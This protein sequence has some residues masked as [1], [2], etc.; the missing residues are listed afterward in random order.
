[1]PRLAKFGKLLGPRGLM[2][3]PKS[4]TISQNPEKKAKELEEGKI[5]FKTEREAPILHLVFGKMDFSDA[6]LIENFQALIQAIGPKN[7]KKAVIKST[8]S[9]GLKV[10]VK[11]YRSQ[12]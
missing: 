7:I 4:G 6:Q 11:G 12:P 1:M 9:P 3:N 8:I 5:Y 2:P 10:L